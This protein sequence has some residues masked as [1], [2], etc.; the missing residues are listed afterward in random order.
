MK[1]ADPSNTCT[2]NQLLYESE[3]FVTKIK[4]MK[5][6]FAFSIIC[7]IFKKIQYEFRLSNLTEQE[8][9]VSRFLLGVT[10]EKTSVRI[11]LNRD[12]HNDEEATV[13]VSEF[14]EAT[15]YPRLE[16]EIGSIKDGHRKMEKPK[17]S[18]VEKARNFPGKKLKG[19]VS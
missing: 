4:I 17:G 14:E 11:E 2:C 16:D 5:L 10:N 8:D 19:S 13:Y 7:I 3:D 6:F 12:P 9:L 18:T 15:R 1:V